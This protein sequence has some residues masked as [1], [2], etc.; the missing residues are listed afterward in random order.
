[1]QIVPG[2][3]VSQRLHLLYTWRMSTLM[4]EAQ[5]QTKLEAEERLAAIK[6]LQAWTSKQKDKDEYLSKSNSQLKLARP[7]AS[8]APETPSRCGGQDHY[9]GTVNPDLLNS[10]FETALYILRILTTLQKHPA[11]SLLGTVCESAQTQAQNKV[12]T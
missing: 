2:A 7:T 6:E 1:M 4:M 11:Q 10:K 3:R 12:S 9:I 5:L 8:T